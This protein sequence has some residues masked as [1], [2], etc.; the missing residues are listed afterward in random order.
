M[1]CAVGAL[2]L[3]RILRNPWDLAAFV[4]MA[5]ICPIGGLGLTLSH[6]FREMRE[7]RRRWKPLAAV[8]L[9]IGVFAIGLIVLS[10]R[11]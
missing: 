8:A 11:S 7:S 5:I 4:I 6:A 2:L 1:F 10:S 3:Y 9:S